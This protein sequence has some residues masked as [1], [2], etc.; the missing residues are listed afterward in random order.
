MFFY[1]MILLLVLCVNIIAAPS[2]YVLTWNDEFNGNSLNNTKWEHRYPGRQY[3]IGYFTSDAISVSDGTIK[4]KT[5]IKNGKVWTGQIGTENKFLTKYGY[6]EI[7]FKLPKIYGPQS[8][9]WLQSPTYGQTIS[10]PGISGVEIDILEYVKTTPNEI[11][12]TL[13]WDGYGVDHKKQHFGFIYPSIANGKWHTVGFLWESTGY[14]LYVD[15]RLR[16]T[17]STAISNVPQYMILS[18]GVTGWG[19]DI[20]KEAIPEGVFEVDYVRVYKK[21]E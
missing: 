10:N 21:G 7:R 3:K 6:Y 1:K 4:I 5:Y 11:H 12:F 19:G 17:T 13:H 2:G 15:G 8:A 9:F 18:A 16:Y 20:F 14:K